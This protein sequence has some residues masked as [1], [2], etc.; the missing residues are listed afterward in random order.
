MGPY[1]QSAKQSVLEVCRLLQESKRIRK[2]G[3]LRVGLISYRDYP[4]EARAYITKPFPFTDDINEVQNHL[5]GLMAREGGNCE[6]FCSAFRDAYYMKG[7]RKGAVKVIV[8]ITDA[9]PHGIGE[10]KDSVKGIAPD[11]T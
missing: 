10:P 6:A 1:I 4:P 7:W 8:I 9:P 3:G 5:N 11:G 2:Q